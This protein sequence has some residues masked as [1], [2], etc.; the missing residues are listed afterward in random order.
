MGIKKYSN[1]FALSLLSVALNQTAYAA[2]ELQTMDEM[3]V[4]ATKSA[5]DTLDAPATVSVIRAKDIEKMNIQSADEALKFIPGAYATSAGGHQPS[6]MST[7]VVLR[8]I[9]DYSRTLVLVD[10]QK[11]N[12]P[13]I[14]A[15]TWESVPPETIERI[16]VVPGPFSSIYGGSA[17]GG[18]INIITK[19]PAK[20]RALVKAGY[21]TDG[22][23][24]GSVLL[25]GKPME[26]LGVSFDYGYK[27]ANGFVMNDVVVARGG[28]AGPVVT[29]GA[30]TT[31]SMGNTRYLIGDKGR[32]PWKSDNTQLKLFADLPHD[33]SLTFDYTHFT[34]TKEWDYFNTYLR[35][36]VG[37]PVSNGGQKTLGVGGPNAKVTETLFLGGPNPKVQ[38]RYALDFTSKLASDMELKFQLSYLNIP[39]YEL[40]RAGAAATYNGGA[41]TRLNRKS[42][43][44]AALAQL[45]FPLSDHHLI[46]T[47]V[48]ANKRSIRTTEYNIADWRNVDLTGAVN[49]RTAGEDRNFAVFLQDD[50]YLTDKFTANIGARYDTVGTSGYVDRMNYGN[51]D[52]GHLS[53]KASL[54]Y[55]PDE[56]TTVRSSIGNAFHVPNLRDTFGW[57]SPTANKPN[58][59]PKDFV[60][61]PDLK[62]ETVTSW[63]LGIEHKFAAGTLVRATYYMSELKDLIYRSSDLFSE[64]VGNAGAGTVRGIELEVRH[65]LASW[66]NVFANATF[67]NSKITQNVAVPTS[68]GKT[69]TNTPE[70]MFNTGLQGSDGPWSGSINLHYVG[71]VY[72]N[73]A[74]LD[75]VNNVNGSYDPFT[76][77]D[78]K[79]SYKVKEN[80]SASLSAD[81]LFN[82]QYYQS[83]RM[84][85][86]AYF[87]EIALQF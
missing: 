86:R 65:P 10:G 18:V 35:D 72:V 30:I 7:T 3:V 22:I 87:G 70:R 21:G 17:M 83:T 48:S 33:S 80:I 46:V 14:G 62:P 9:P 61:N 57:W 43:E 78:A 16:E 1:C 55:R 31:D 28:A 75:I 15:V 66:L 53:P 54:I 36:V 79:I 82:R 11:L 73:A 27:A 32:V 74:N 67:N 19:K 81:N 69:M 50:I 23:R 51:R 20:T 71:K 60:P 29:G 68:V 13:F 37:N 6:V 64:T 12:D 25:E 4:T 56:T 34:Y 47:G 39:T 76:I 2:D 63:E 8:G 45:S 52:K 85:G 58:G 84:Q 5:K 77:V 49:H 26:K 42:D 44:L 38:D 59:T 41:G 40:V 24:I